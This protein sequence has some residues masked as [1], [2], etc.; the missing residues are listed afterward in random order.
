M[1]RGRN[2]ACNP[3]P[4]FWKCSGKA[5]STSQVPNP[6]RLIRSPPCAL[7]ESVKPCAN[8]T[9]RP[10]MSRLPD[11]PRLWHLTSTSSTG[12]MRLE[13]RKKEVRRRKQRRRGPW[14]HYT[15]LTAPH[16]QPC[17][18]F[19]WLSYGRTQGPT[20]RNNLQLLYH[21]ICLNDTQLKQPQANRQ[22]QEPHYN[23]RRG[24]APRTGRQEARRIG[25]VLNRSF[26]RKGRHQT[27][28]CLSVL[29]Y[30]HLKVHLSYITPWVPQT[31]SHPIFQAPEN[32]YSTKTDPT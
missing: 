9:A 23:F 26:F 10:S 7:S 11:H 24:L 22:L 13:S 25:W 14:A 15:P 2:S 4:G 8:T 1:S 16:F 17:T 21:C 18:D 27:N 12:E 19:L 30:N 3:Q 29:K 5:L 31:Y 28:Q 32:P 6:T 20:L